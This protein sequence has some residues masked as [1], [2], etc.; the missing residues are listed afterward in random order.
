MPLV[1]H[2]PLQ[3]AAV[4]EDPRVEAR[5]LREFATAPA[6]SRRALLIASAGCTALYL[7][8]QL[9]DLHLELLDPNPAQLQHVERK[10]RALADFDPARFD[11]DTR[12]GTG[13][14][15][16]GNFERLFRLLRA[17][18]DEFVIPAEE[19]RRRLELG[20]RADDWRD[21]VEHA[22]WPSAF[23]AAF[24]DDLLIATFGPDAVQHAER[25]SYP[26][27]F[28]RRI[29]LGL[30]ADD[31]GDNP[32]LHHVLLGHYLPRRS[33]W[34]P[35]LQNAPVTLPQLPT[36]RASLLDAPP[37]GRFD[38]VQLSNVMDW[39][40]PAACRAL[41]ERL[42]REMRPGTA[43]LWRQLNNERDLTG[44]FRPAFTFDERRDAELT[45]T[46]RSLFYNRVHHGVRQ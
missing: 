32:W 23:A 25:G 40:A 28:R 19:R 22:Y 9:P 42:C 20:A 16:C 39:M 34:P 30:A 43:I 46:E 14:H 2:L 27:Y 1:R 17:S 11:V 3:F 6:A 41:A 5:V 21:V 10:R 38:F 13:L 12:A 45:R 24:S 29:E 36:H 15:E 35:Y 7:Q 33:A 8:Q 31:R 4:R 44:L 26:A 37:F 18:L